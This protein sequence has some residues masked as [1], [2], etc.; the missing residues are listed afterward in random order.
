MPG[1]SGYMRI[2]E[3]GGGD[4]YLKAA[5][6]FFGMLVPHRMFSHGGLGGN[7]PG[8]N[9]NIEMFQNRDNIANAIAQGGA[10]T[11]SIYNVSKLARNL[12]FHTQD[13]AYMDYYERALFNQLAGSRADSTVDRATRRSPT[14]SR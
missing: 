5:K 11:C 2:F 3:Q 7:Y 12:F 10:E 4:D 14:S 1:F 6:N 13:P 8:S 9:N